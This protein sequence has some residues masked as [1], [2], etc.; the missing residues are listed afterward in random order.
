MNNQRDSGVTWWGR[1]TVFL[2]LLPFVVLVTSWLYAA[3]NAPNG[4]MFEIST[5]NVTA[6]RTRVAVGETVHFACSVTTTNPGFEGELGISWSGAGVAGFGSFLTNEFKT[7]GIETITATVSGTP[8]NGPCDKSNTVTV[9][10]VKIADMTY[11]WGGHDWMPLAATNYV[12]VGATVEF[13]AIPEPAGDWPAGKPV[14]SVAS[15][16]STGS[17]TFVSAGYRDVTAECGNSI[18]AAMCVFKV[19][20]E[21][22]TY[23]YGYMHVDNLVG[24]WTQRNFGVKVRFTP[25]IPSLPTDF[26]V[27]HASSITP[28]ENNSREFSF[29]RNTLGMETITAE[30]PQLSIIKKV[31]IDYPDVGAYSENE[32]IFIHPFLAA[33][34]AYYGLAAQNYAETLV[35]GGMEDSHANAIQHSYWAS[36]MASDPTI[37]P[38]YSI[39]VTTAH[40]HMNFD[41][42]GLAHDTVM[43]LHNNYVGSTVI[44][45]DPSGMLQ[46]GLIQTD[47]AAK[48]TAGD[49]WIIN[50]ADQ[51]V[52][53][54]NGNK[55]FP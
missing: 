49:L 44:H 50:D 5:V 29:A 22:T 36:L 32:L 55:I 20:L 28:P 30:F 16:G 33:G 47:L 11:R 31:I 8:T 48:L 54:S 39:W 45:T 46:V 2:S 10:V 25:D 23:P 15:G 1:N 17:V 24:V 18:T 12:P 37:G 42:G 21:G 26:I 53:K 27:W 35:T 40:E 4:T 14:W 13:L 52:I 43:D 6:D 9:A 7:A 51:M 41:D 19:E 34:A 38:T 3:C